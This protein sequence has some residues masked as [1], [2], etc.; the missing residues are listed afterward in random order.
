MIIIDVVRLEH[1]Q[2]SSMCK[3]VDVAYFT[4]HLFLA[5]LLLLRNGLAAV[6]HDSGVARLCVCV[7]CIEG[8]GRVEQAANW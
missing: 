2:W 1:C 3:G 7:C 8:K 4:Y 6:L 5:L